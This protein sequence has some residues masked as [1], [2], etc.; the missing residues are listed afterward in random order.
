MRSGNPRTTGFPTSA[1][2]LVGRVLLLVLAVISIQYLAT[3]GRA[4][5]WQWKA[6]ESPHFRVQWLHEWGVWFYRERGADG[7]PASGYKLMRGV[8]PIDPDDGPNWEI[9]I[10][11]WIP[12]LG[13]MAVLVAT[14]LHL[15][16]G[17]KTQPGSPE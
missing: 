3:L 2:R 14:G 16:R 12:A 5:A 17:R 4:M 13:A 6:S 9:K 10:P 15:G 1:L 7:Q 8:S 11:A